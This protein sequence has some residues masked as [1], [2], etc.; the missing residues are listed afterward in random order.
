MLT[1]KQ[2]VKIL[3]H[4]IKEEEKQDKLDQALREYAPSDFTG[5]SKPDETTFLVGVLEELM[6]DKPQGEYNSTYI[7]W[8]LWDCP[9]RGRC[10]NDDS[11]TIW[12][13]ERDDENTDKIVVRTP[14]DLYDV[15]LIEYGKAPTKESVQMAVKA[16]DNGVKF[17]LHYLN[18]LKKNNKET[19]NE[20][21]EERNALLDLASH[22]IT[23]E[24]LLQ[25]GTGADLNFEK[26]FNII[27]ILED[28]P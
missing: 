22:K 16:Q 8:W 3:N 26:D 15:L 13:G 24:Y 11:C 12:F 6:G 10:K 9:D 25:R 23:N 18:V 2:F 20:G 5:F 19:K 28:E 21:W 1:K 27:S 4:I 14:E 17:A 7:S